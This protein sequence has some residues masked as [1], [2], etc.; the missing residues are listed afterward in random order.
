M[1]ILADEN[2]D[3]LIV[4]ALRRAGH[5]VSYVAEWGSG[6]TDAAVFATRQREGRVLL[7]HDQDFG[8]M[9]KRASSRPE[10]IVLLRLE[11]LSRSTRAE[12]VTKALELLGDSVRGRLIV[13]EPGHMRDRA[14]TS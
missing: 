11:R 1:K 5:D 7:T 9:A 2:C 4:S 6:L 10:A 14:L 12:M 13:S 8:L 3:S